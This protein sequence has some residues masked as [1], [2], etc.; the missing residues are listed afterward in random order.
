MI[1]G[2]EAIVRCLENEGVE[3]IFGYPGAT[4]APLYDK[5][6]K[7]N[8]KHILVRHEQHAG[9]EASGYARIRKRPGVCMTT[10]GPGATN[11]ITAL[12]TAYMDSIPL[13]AFTGQVS[14]ELL[15][16][17]VFQEADITGAA[18]PFTKY[19]YLVK[20]PEDLPRVIH[21]AFHIASTGRP[22]PVL[23]DIPVNVQTKRFDFTLPAAVDLRGYKP[24]IK[25]HAGQ[26]KRVKQAINNAERPV[27][28]VGGGIFAS[29][30]QRELAQFAETLNI[31]VVSTMMG[32]GAIPTAH[33][34]YMG[35]LGMHGKSV[36]NQAIS[37]CDLLIIIG[38]RVSDRA[39]LLPANVG[40]GTKIVHIDIDPAEIGKNVSTLIPVVGDAKEILT[41]IMEVEP[42]P[43][44]GE[45]VGALQDKREK[46]TL[47]Y[48]PRE[49]GIN[50]KAFVNMLSLSLPED[51]VYCADVGQNQIWSAA[52]CEVRTG[53]FLTS[54]GMG[55]MGYS[56]P[57][58]IGAKLAD[59]SKTVVAVC[60]DGS[61]QMEMMELATIC[62]NGVDVKIVVMKNN[63][64]GLV[65]EIQKNSYKNNEFAVDLTGSPDIVAIAG[66]YGIPGKSIDNMD[67]AKEAIAE[68]LGHKGA[69]LLE[70]IV[71]E[72]ES[73]L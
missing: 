34:L 8:I 59:P 38:A 51:H 43:K 64:L 18:E 70:C 72:N 46:L 67:A 16:R 52:N 2:A 62:Q 13:V 17:D 21:E 27:I 3:V 65:K 50:P 61:F 44:T 57:A 53:R 63:K 7:S 54:G 73:S 60:G 71:D 55:T 25:G 33:P 30:G 15:G 39:V 5:L 31:P 32:I 69:Y 41:Q 12:A 48:E 6:T 68:M 42:A 14:S 23:I 9:H 66:A 22:G 58:A 28:C 19:S 56:I 26:I 24:T 37:N 49:F 10:S 45:W 35:M 11:L 36:A 20:N 4:I 40:K 1:T 29:D 47:D